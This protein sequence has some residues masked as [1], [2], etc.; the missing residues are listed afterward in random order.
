LHLRIT[1]EAIKVRVRV[2]FR[3]G[4]RVRVEGYL[5]TKSIKGD[6]QLLAQD[7]NIM[8]N[9]GITLKRGMTSQDET[10][11]GKT[12]QEKTRWK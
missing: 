3:V 12:T 2:R 8:V 5:L 4:V 1:V 7:H 10:R 6:S 9:I 11:Q